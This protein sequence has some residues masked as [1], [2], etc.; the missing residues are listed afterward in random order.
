VVSLLV[1]EDASD[2]DCAGALEAYTGGSVPETAAE[3]GR[4]AQWRDDMRKAAM[5]RH[6]EKRRPFTG[7]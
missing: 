5:V 2:E 1:G 3:E 7:L 4:V 6:K